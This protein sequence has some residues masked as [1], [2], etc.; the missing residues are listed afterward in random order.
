MYLLSFDIYFKNISFNHKRNL[1]CINHYK[2]FLLFQSIGFSKF[3]FWKFG[4]V[5]FKFYLCWSRTN[6][7]I[8]CKQLSKVTA[9]MILSVSLCYAL[10]LKINLVPLSEFWRKEWEFWWWGDCWLGLIRAR[11]P[12]TSRVKMEQS[13]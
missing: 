12:E 5:M 11:T 13:A 4:K 3:W 7:T 8:I 6:T 10:S 9:R 2:S 1:A